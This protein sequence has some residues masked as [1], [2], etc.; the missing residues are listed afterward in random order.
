M[1]PPKYLIPWSRSCS[2]TKYA[3]KITVEL[4]KLS[5]DH[6]Y[7]DIVHVISEL[8]RRKKSLNLGKILLKS[9]HQPSLPWSTVWYVWSKIRWRK[10]SPSLHHKTDAMACSASPTCSTLLLLPTPTLD[11]ASQAAS[12]A[13]SGGDP[14]P[15]NDEYGFYYYQQQVIISRQRRYYL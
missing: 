11:Y 1:T 8:E 13:A 14:E 9:F 6:C 4:D 7:G 5:P 3:I 12:F 2:E 15:K 10:S